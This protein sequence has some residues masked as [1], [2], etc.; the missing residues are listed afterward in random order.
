MSRDIRL[1]T[2]FENEPAQWGLRGDPYLWR[3]MKDA[4]LSYP[5]PATDVELIAIL[6]D[7]FAELTGESLEGDGPL[8]VKKFA[9]GGMSSGQ[10]SREFWRNSAFPLLLLRHAGT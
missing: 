1:S 2:L 6:E 9:H 10:V 3:D 5:W 4:A 7:M 8:F